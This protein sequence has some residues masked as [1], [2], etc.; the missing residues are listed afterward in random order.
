MLII[1]RD[2]PV[3][4][5]SLPIKVHHETAAGTNSGLASIGDKHCVT[6]FFVLALKTLNA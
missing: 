6:A 2:N 4:E 5:S 1:R 3:H